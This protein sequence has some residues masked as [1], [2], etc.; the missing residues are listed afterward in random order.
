MT[1]FFLIGHSEE[2][3]VFFPDD[4]RISLVKLKGRGFED[5]ILVT[6]Y[7]FQFELIELILKLFL[8]S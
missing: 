8:S 5:D 6:F 7:L 2:S 1:E 4:V 3:G